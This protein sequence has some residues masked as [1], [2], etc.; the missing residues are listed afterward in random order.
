MAYKRPPGAPNADFARARVFEEQV[1][2]QLGDW[3]VTRFDAVDDL[4][5]WIP[6]Y[7]L[8]VKQKNQPLT[9]RWHLL[10]GVPEPDLVVLDE[11]GVR[12]VM[13]K[14]PH[15]YVLIQDVPSDRLFLASAAELATVERARVNRDTGTVKKGK[16][17][18]SLRSFRQIPA[19]AAI[20]AL[21]M[22]ELTAM[23]WKQSPCL[24]HGP[25]REV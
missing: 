1:A 3:T 18:Y 7:Y 2:A 15:S 14:Y 20:P 21:V 23:P 8:E 9:A 25:I 17:I 5:I 19:V 4:D 16:L 11:L 13:E 22:S 24:G 6:G 10:P 12:R